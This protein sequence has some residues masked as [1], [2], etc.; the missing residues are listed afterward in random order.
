MTDAPYRGAIPFIVTDRR[1]I[2]VRRGAVIAGPI[3]RRY[4]GRP[5]VL[6][7]P[8]SHLTDSQAEV[9]VPTREE[10]VR[11]HAEWFDALPYDSP[12]KQAIRD[13]AAIVRGG[14][15]LALECW[16]A[17]HSCHADTLRDRI[18]ALADSEEDPTC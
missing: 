2:V 16:C 5:D 14:G 4:V 6:G 3:A 18:L 7:N 1:V 10:A 13:L 17:P 15:R 11:R 9:V 8:F 12:Q